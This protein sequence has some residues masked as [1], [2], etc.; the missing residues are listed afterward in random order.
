MLEAVVKSPYAMGL[1]LVL[2][3]YLERHG[4]LDSLGDVKSRGVIRLESWLAATDGDLPLSIWPKMR[5]LTYRELRG[6][7]PGLPAMGD[8]CYASSRGLWLP[9]QEA[10]RFAVTALKGA[11]MRRVPSKPE[12]APIPIN[13]APSASKLSDTGSE[14]LM[15]FDDVGPIVTGYLPAIET[16]EDIELRIAESEKRKSPGSDHYGLLDQSIIPK[17]L[18]QNPKTRPGILWKSGLGGAS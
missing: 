9:F 13:P 16:L 11:W 18:T 10:S 17:I 5:Q 8:L 15:N 2:H 1:S 6:T 3:E 12:V 14:L 7:D 4:E